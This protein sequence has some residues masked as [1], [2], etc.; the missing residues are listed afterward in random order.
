LGNHHLVGSTTNKLTEAEFDSIVTQIEISFDRGNIAECIDIIKWNF[1]DR[2]FSFFNLFKD[3]QLKLLNRLTEQYEQMAL[4]SYDKIYEQSY[5]LLNLM[6]SE[7]HNI[8]S[9]LQRNLENVF[10]FKLEEMLDANS[11][12]FSMTRFQRYAVEIRKW[13][14]QLDKERI[15]FHASQF[16][17]HHVA[18]FADFNV[19]TEWVTRAYTFLDTLYA[20][21]IFPYIN[22]LQDFVFRLASENHL[23]PE[24]KR[25]VYRLAELINLDLEPVVMKKTQKKKVI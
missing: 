6:R 21:N 19:K 16:I 9:M 11:E 13:N 22:E 18:Q 17:S 10:Q 5:S 12:K 3:E 7:K 4:E 20:I 1:Q 15:Q 23:S 25:E 24:M 14:A 8:P 2:S